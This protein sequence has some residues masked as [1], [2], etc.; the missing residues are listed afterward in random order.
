MAVPARV[1]AGA[2]PRRCQLTENYEDALRKVTD[3][4]LALVIGAVAEAVGGAGPIIIAGRID[5]R[6]HV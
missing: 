2:E 3:E 6:W 5:D 1:A 4:E